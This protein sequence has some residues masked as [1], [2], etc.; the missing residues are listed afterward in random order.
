MS[1][2][3]TTT[4]TRISSFSMAAAIGMNALFLVGIASI[5]GH[6]VPFPDDGTNTTFEPQPTPPVPVRHQKKQVTP[7]A[8]PVP[9]R[10][11][12]TDFVPVLPPLDVT[13]KIMPQR[14]DPPVLPYIPPITL[15]PAP[16]ITNARFD[17][18]FASAMQP[19]Y[20][21]ALARAEIEGVA[22]VKVRIGTD[23]RV[24]DVISIRTDDPGFFE[25]TRAHALR[26]WRFKPATRDGVAIESW[27]E[28]T[29]RFQMPSRFE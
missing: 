6:F 16:V 25:V 14:F 12:V 18:R 27:R 17:P 8:T 22:I 3:D 1:Y 28:M 2:V 9:F 20:P 15:T 13:E 26:K 5:S 11:L 10:P 29:V 4:P 7:K 21:I 19:E 23:G 24:L